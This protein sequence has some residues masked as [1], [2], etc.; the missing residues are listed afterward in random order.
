MYAAIAGIFV[1]VL[2]CCFRFDCFQPD[3]HCSFSKSC[4][5]SYI[6]EEEKIIKEEFSKK[7]SEF[8][9]TIMLYHISLTNTKSFVFKV[10]QNISQSSSDFNILVTIGNLL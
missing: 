1:F 6:P 4:R 10:K 3:M 2:I 5:C 8:L 7:I 9:G